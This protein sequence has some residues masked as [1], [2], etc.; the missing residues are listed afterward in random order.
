MKKTILAGLIL[1]S[2]NVAHAASTAGADAT[3]VSSTAST[4]TALGQNAQNIT[5]N[6]PGV[7]DE[8]LHTT[9]TVY[10]PS[11]ANSL[12]QAN[13]MVIPTAG[14]SFMN[15]GFAGSLPVD[16]LHCD[17]RQNTALELQTF[18]NYRAYMTTPGLTAVSVQKA[19]MLAE[20]SLDAAVN[21][22]CLNS[23]RQRAVMEKLG[24][25]KDVADLATLDHRF[26]QPRNYQVDY[27]KSE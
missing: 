9:P 13:C 11:P 19:A 24:M 10:V 22:Q 4:S 6:N 23:D 1:L 17:W 8:T 21:M 15:F 16:G 2:L 26:N 20:K 14:A 7:S 5:F 27:S 18:A 25:C 12:A 3:N